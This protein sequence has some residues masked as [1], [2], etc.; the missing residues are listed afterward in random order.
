MCIWTIAGNHRGVV[1]NYVDII[2]VKGA[3]ESGELPHDGVISP[4]VKERAVDLEK[5]SKIFEKN[6]LINIYYNNL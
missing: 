5:S 4:S 6:L 2:S 3:R 1:R